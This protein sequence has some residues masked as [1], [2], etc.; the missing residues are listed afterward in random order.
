MGGDVL[1]LDRAEPSMYEGDCELGG[2]RWI[3]CADKKNSVLALVRHDGHGAPGV[4]VI[5]NLSGCARDNYRV[6]VP[7]AGTYKEALNTDSSYYGGWNFGNLGEVRTEDIPA[8]CHPQSLSITLP[9]MSALFLKRIEAGSKKP[10][11][12]KPAK[13]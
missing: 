13:K 12:K 11:S 7:V 8:H 9:P 2:F 1:R 5:V 10:A 4:V 6:G 3:D